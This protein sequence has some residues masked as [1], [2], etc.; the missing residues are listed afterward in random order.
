MAYEFY[1]ELLTERKLE[2]NW[3]ALLA[4]IRWRL[5]FTIDALR[6][7]LQHFEASKGESLA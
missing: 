2:V 7:E 3:H 6:I 4:T 5:G 1:S